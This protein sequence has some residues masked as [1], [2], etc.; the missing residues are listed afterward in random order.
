MSKERWNVED[1][2]KTAGMND[3]QRRTMMHMQRIRP[4]VRRQDYYSI[5]GVSRSATLHEIKTA[6][7]KLALAVAPDKNPG[8]DTTE[9]FQTVNKAYE[10]LSDESKRREYDAGGQREDFDNESEED[11]D[12]SLVQFGSRLTSGGRASTMFRNLY[13]TEKASNKQWIRGA[14]MANA[15]I[16]KCTQELC[17]RINALGSVGSPPPVAAFVECCICQVQLCRPSDSRA[18]FIEEEHMSKEHNAYITRI[19]MIR[20][21]LNHPSSVEAVLYPEQV[22]CPIPLRRHLTATQS[23]CPPVLFRRLA[24]ELSQIPRNLFE[25]CGEWRGF[26][27][28]LETSCDR[29]SGALSMLDIK[30][31]ILNATES[32]PKGP[33]GRIPAREV[34]S[35]FVSPLSRSRF[36]R[37]VSRFSRRRNLILDSKR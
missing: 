5:L 33:S 13:E 17:A 6:Y 7:R 3:R 30:E 14:F 22:P 19:A 29:H 1:M 10:V 20:E 27:T 34:R 26:L 24:E 37:V 2:E 23:N 31:N 16:H 11:A 18:K 4:F 36:S 35:N 32:L 8:L 25:E 9:I 12:E 15:H 21:S 28:Y